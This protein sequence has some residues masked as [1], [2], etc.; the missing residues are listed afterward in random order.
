MMVPSGMSG[1]LCSSAAAQPPGCGYDGMI[2]L[3]SQAQR[4]A[5]L[6]GGLECRPRDIATEIVGEFLFATPLPA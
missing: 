2:T 6:M 4:S 5:G 3:A 1:T